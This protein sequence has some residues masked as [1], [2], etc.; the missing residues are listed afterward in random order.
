MRSLFYIVGLSAFIVG[1]AD[2]VNTSAPPAKDNTAINERDEDGHTATPADQSNEQPDIDLTAK[3]RASVL[4]IEDLSVNG[5]NVKII[6]NDGNVIL[7]GPVATAAEKD[8][9][10]E[11]AVR[12]AGDGH[13]TNELEVVPDKE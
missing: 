12:I 4:E 13:V 8:R 7:R 11:V 10:G 6:S 9:I 3:I 5:R 1:C 2:G